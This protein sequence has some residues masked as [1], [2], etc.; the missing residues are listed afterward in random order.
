MDADGHFQGIGRDDGRCGDEMKI[1][2]FKRSFSVEPLGIAYLSSCLKRAGHQTKLIIIDKP[3]YRERIR[4]FAPDMFAYS[5]CTGEHKDWFAF[6]RNMKDEW[7]DVVSVFGGPHATFFPEMA[8]VEGVDATIRGEAEET[9]VDFVNKVEAYGRENIVR[10]DEYTVRLGRLEQDL[11]SIPFPDRAFLYSYPE[12]RNNPVR[13]IMLSRGCNFSCTYCYNGIY[14]DLHPGQ[15]TYRQRSVDNVIEEAKRLRWEYPETGFIFFQDDNFIPNNAMLENFVTLWSREVG[16]PF[17]C[18]FRADMMT[19]KRAK[20]LSAAGC[21]SATFAI[22]TGNDQL[23]RDMLKRNM[24]KEH[25][26]NCVECLRA[27]NIRFRSENMIGLPG[28]SFDEALETLDL[29]IQVKPDAA[30]CALFQPYPKTPLG[31]LAKQMHVWDGDVDDITPSFFDRCPVKRDTAKWFDNLQKWFGLIVAFPILRP[32]VKILVRLP[33]MKV[34]SWISTK[35]RRYCY[36]KK[37]YRVRN[38]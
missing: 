35:Y 9:F 34:M 31:E 32:F 37:L 17:H 13:N 38:I 3:D 16:I 12:N 8:S 22:E 15:I 25:I 20:M 14:R 10:S 19:P 26:R 29:N 7:P 6:N 21:I 11:D 30:F 27:E 28:E 23:R 33:R 18:Q 1:C 2:F 4:S 36:D 5:T 24:T